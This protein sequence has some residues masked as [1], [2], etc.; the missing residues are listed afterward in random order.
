MNFVAEK[1]MCAE[2]GQEELQ[3]LSPAEKA[4]YL[5]IPLEEYEAIMRSVIGD[6]QR[7]Q[8]AGSVPQPYRTKRVRALAHLN[9][10]ENGNRCGCMLGAADAG[11][12][13]YMLN[14]EC[15]DVGEI[16]PYILDVPRLREAYDGWLM[17]TPEERA[18]WQAANPAEDYSRAR[19]CCIM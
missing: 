15:S 1:T 2:L 10:R 11:V 18:A 16:G 4:A 12:L 5:E 8:H 7:G 13:L 6:V 14:Y 17:Q 3:E 9:A 19:K